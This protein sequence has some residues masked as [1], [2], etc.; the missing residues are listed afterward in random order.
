MTFPLYRGGNP[1]PA[2]DRNASDTSDLCEHDTE[3]I[4]HQSTGYLNDTSAWLC[5]DC[6]SEVVS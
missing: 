2:P 4:W 1:Y 3:P 5:P 6:G